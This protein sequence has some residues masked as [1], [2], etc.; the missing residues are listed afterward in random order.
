MSLPTT[1]PE[2]TMHAT[3]N[4]AITATLVTAGA[5]T[6]FLP[7]VAGRHYLRAEQSVYN[8][9]DYLAPDY[10]GGFWNYYDLS[11]GGFYMAPQLDGRM[12]VEVDGNGYS[13]EMSADAAGIVACLFMLCGLAAK[14]HDDTIIDRYHQLRAFA[15]EHAEA[16][17]ILRAI[18]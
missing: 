13:G 2:N 10:T 5:R 17:Q 16:S 7:R 15:C 18:D 14:T 4:T 12:R 8:Y 3:D 11:N 1:T 9:M 6:A